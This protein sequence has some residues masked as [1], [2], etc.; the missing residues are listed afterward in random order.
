MKGKERQIN[1]DKQR[2]T[3]IYILYRSMDASDTMKKKK[4][5]AI[6]TNQLAAYIAKNPGGDC[7]NLNTC[8][9]A[10]NCNMTFPTYENKYEFFQG[11]NNCT[12]C[13]CAENGGSK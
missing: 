5:Q 10:N 11:R 8:T 9:P 1:K 6:Y 12:G 7:S 13:E 4:A 3:K 2:Q